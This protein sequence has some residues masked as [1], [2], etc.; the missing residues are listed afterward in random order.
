MK[1]WLEHAE[2]K[3]GMV[4]RIFTPRATVGRTAIAPQEVAR[5]IRRVRRSLNAGRNSTES[6]RPTIHIPAHSI[7]IGASHNLAASGID[8]MSIMHCGG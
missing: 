7:Q 2:V 6:V 4:F 5:I 3:D 8:L 1:H